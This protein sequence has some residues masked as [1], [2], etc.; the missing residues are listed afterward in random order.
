VVALYSAIQEE[1]VEAN[2]EASI[3]ASRNKKKQEGRREAGGDRPT[4]CIY[5]GGG[6]G[7]CS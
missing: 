1:E 6:E 5:C 4:G 3:E 7:F 2:M